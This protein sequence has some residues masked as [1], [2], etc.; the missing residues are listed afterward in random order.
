[1]ACRSCISSRK[2]C[3]LLQARF[4]YLFYLFD[5]SVLLRCSCAESEVAVG[6]A[7]GSAR[8]YDLYGGRCSRILRLQSFSLPNYAASYLGLRIV[9]PQ[10]DI[11]AQELVIEPLVYLTGE[12]KKPVA[13]AFNNNTYTLDL[14]QLVREFTVRSH[15]QESVSLIF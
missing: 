13:T 7:D 12:F 8:I 9:F 14:L 15:L 3:A 5:F 2:N 10:V 4:I 1:M 6:C 11:T